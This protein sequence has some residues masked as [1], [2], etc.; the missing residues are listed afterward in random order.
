[1]NLRFANAQ[2]IWKETIEKEER[3]KRSYYLGRFRGSATDEDGGPYDPWNNEKVSPLNG[4]HRCLVVPDRFAYQTIDMLS[5][6]T[7]CLRSP[8]SRSAPALPGTPSNLSRTLA[9]RITVTNPEALPGYGGSVKDLE[10]SGTWAVKDLRGSLGWPVSSTGFGMGIDPRLLCRASPSSAAGVPGSSSARQESPR[11]S[12]RAVSKRSGASAA[13]SMRNAVANAVKTELGKSLKGASYATHV[14]ANLHAAK[15]KAP[16]AT[17][18]V[19]SYMFE[20]EWPKGVP[21]SV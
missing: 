13:K 7:P 3:L 19:P 10:L 6:T 20:A 12:S 16:P 1:M 15:G 17:S 2:S 11:A 4:I 21:D 18:A 14:E 5:Q 8:M 9:S